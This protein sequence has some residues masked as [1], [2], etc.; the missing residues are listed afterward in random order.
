MCANYGCSRD[1]ATVLNMQT[2]DVATIGRES[3]EPGFHVHEDGTSHV[4]DH[5]HHAHDHRHGHDHHHDH[6]HGPV[7]PDRERQIPA[8]HRHGSASPRSTGPLLDLEARILAKNDAQAAK[9][10]SW[11]AGREIFAL[12]LLSSPG[13]GKTSL[14]ERTIADLGRELPLFVVEGDQ[15]TARDGERIR[16]AGAPV[17]QINTGTGCHLDAEMV[18]RAL[19]ELKPTIGA[20]VLIEN[21]GNLVCPALFDL[22]ERAKVVIFSA[23]E[24]EDKPLKYPHMFAAATLVLLNK[25]DLL[26]Y[27]DFSVDQAIANVRRVNPTATV[28]QVSART[29]DGL[30]AWCDWLRAEVLAARQFAL[31]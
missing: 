17:A 26:P 22:G 21:V 25:I 2:G 6:D 28:L 13:S 3:T 20:I 1:G 18:A 10:R 14:L 24:G 15:A 8:E 29:R 19:S 23:T 27:L 30:P 4:H 9:N 12:N 11:L 5:Q 16:A 31:V 7:A